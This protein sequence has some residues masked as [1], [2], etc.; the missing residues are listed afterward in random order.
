MEVGPLSA[1]PTEQGG[2]TKALSPTKNALHY[3]NRKYDTYYRM[4]MWLVGAEIG[5][6][7]M[8]QQQ[9]E[10]GVREATNCCG[11]EQTWLMFS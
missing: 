2:T 8:H 1:S 11:A 6:K 4:I 7:H 10:S 5:A 9:S 3:P